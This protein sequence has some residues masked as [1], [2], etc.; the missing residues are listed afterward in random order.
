M[1]CGP[2]RF[3]G[4]E[5]A[6]FRLPVATWKGL[7]ARYYPDTA[8]LA[9]RKEVFDRLQQFKCRSG[10][11]SWEEALEALLASEEAVSS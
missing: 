4:I 6:K 1:A 2:R 5:E 3:R 10:S 9:L 7:L 8:W 11:T